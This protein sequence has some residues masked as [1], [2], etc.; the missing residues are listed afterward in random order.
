MILQQHYNTTICCLT[1]TN[2]MTGWNLNTIGPLIAQNCIIG[3]FAGLR[4]KTHLHHNEAL[5]TRCVPE[6]LN[7]VGAC[8]IRCVIMLWSYPFIRFC[9]VRKHKLEMGNVLC[10]IAL[11]LKIWNIRAS[12]VI[13]SLFLNLLTMFHHNIYSRLAPILKEQCYTSI[14]E[15]FRNYIFSVSC[16]ILGKVP[17]VTATNAPIS[18]QIHTVIISFN[19]GIT[20]TVFLTT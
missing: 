13:H 19:S 12:A 1:I 14:S 10:V 4:Y 16:A 3:H 8:S 9:P 2:E 6:L 7:K 20:R 18:P 11:L 5:P 17:V 15:L